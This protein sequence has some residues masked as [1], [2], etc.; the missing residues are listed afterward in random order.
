MKKSL[1]WRPAK[2]NFLC[3]I[4]IGFLLVPQLGFAQKKKTLSTNGKAFKHLERPTVKSMNT[5]CGQA[6]FRTID[7]TCN[8]TTSADKTEWGA[9]DIQLLRVVDSNYGEP[10]IWNDMGG[11]DRPS[12]RTVSNNIVAQEESLESGQNL[13]SFVFTWGQFLDHDIDLT[14]E[15][16]AEYQPIELPADE[17]LLTYDIPFH[18]S[19]IHEG[20]GQNNPRE[21]TN[22]ITSWIDASNVYGSDEDRAH[23][24]RVFSDGKLKT[25]AGNLLPFNTFDGEY[26]S[27]I[28]PNAP[29]MAGDDGGSTKTYVAGDVRAGEQP[30]LTS[31]H[32]LFVREHNRACDRLKN[33]GIQGDEQIYQLARKHVGALI[34][35]ITF[36]E[37]LPALGIQ[38]PQNSTYNPN[39]RPDIKN[40]FATAAYRLGHTMVTEELFLRNNDCEAFQAGS[41]SLLDGFFNPAILQTYNISPILKGL[42]IQVQQEVDVLIIDNLRNLLFANPDIPGTFGLDLASLNIQRGRDH[43]LPDYNTI[44]AH[45]LGQPAQNFGQITD[46]PALRNALQNTYDDLNDI[47]PWVG[48][49]AENHMPGKSVGRTLNAILS[50]QFISLRDGDFYYF[51]RDPYLPDQEKQRIRNTK[52]S[53]ILLRNTNIDNLSDNV[54]IA[55]NCQMQPP[56]GGGGNNGPGGGNGGGGGGNNGPGG[57]NGGGGGG[58]NGPGGGNGGGGG[59]SIAPMIGNSNTTSSLIAY[60][61]PTADFIQIQLQASEMESAHIRLFDGSGR[62]TNQVIQ[63]GLVGFLNYRMDLSK[64]VPGI[65]MLQVQTETGVF[66]RKVVL[67]GR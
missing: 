39:I 20:T 13:S 61:N 59:N 16:E 40:L 28:D 55:D 22:L 60:P 14:P 38:L 42:S 27:E 5:N 15:S 58:N 44:R 66:A 67:N 11:Q 24:L 29:S 19:A 41:I 57:G 35:N 63:T 43:G 30:G 10:D 47:D 37:F 23:W 33:Q 12:P 2:W 9:T 64:L 18:R 34:Q 1:N 62:M 8:N 54:F 6:T 32:T 3:L 50:D 51:E 49:L 31:L 53:D 17:P 7:G 48:M 4:L 25:S 26:D 65:Y 45:Y 56:S 46:D 21:Q 36:N 52:L